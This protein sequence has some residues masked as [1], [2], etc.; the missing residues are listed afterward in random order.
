MGR[1]FKEAAPVTLGYAGSDSKS[2]PVSF[3]HKPASSHEGTVSL[4]VSFL[5][6]HKTLLIK[7]NILRREG[8]ENKEFTKLLKF[9]KEANMDLSL[10]KGKNKE[11][12]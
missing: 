6:A 9:S 1:L 5:N 11:L 2:W 8:N 12:V 3:L 7:L 10:E 4:K